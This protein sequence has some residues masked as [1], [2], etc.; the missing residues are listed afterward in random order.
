ML[1]LV[2]E[3]TRWLTRPTGP[4]GLSRVR[5]DRLMQESTREL[6]MENELP[7]ACGSHSHGRQRPRA[8]KTAAWS[9]VRAVSPQLWQKGVLARL[10]VPVALALVLVSRLV[11]IGR[12]VLLPDEAYYWD[13][14]RRLD[15]GY[16]D[17]P[18]LVAL[19][20]RT[21]T[22]IVGTSEFT[23]RVGMAMLGVGTAALAYR[24][25]VLLSGRLAGWLCLLATATCPLFVLLSGFAA[26]D[27]PLLFLWA[28]TVY[29][30]LRA[31]VTGCG[32]YWYAAGI[33]L[34]LALLAKYV[35]VLLIPSILLF[36]S[37]SRRGWLR[38]REP[39]LA[40]ALAL[41][42]FSPNVWWNLRHGW[43]SMSFQLAHGACQAGSSPSNHL[44]AVDVYAVTQVAIVGPLLA[45]ALVVATA[46]AL[47]RGVRQRQDVALLLVCCT[48]PTSILF[49]AVQGLAH[50]AAP[51]YFSA[52]ICASVFL[53]RVLR[54]AAGWQR[55]LLII[56]CVATLL[57]LAFESTSIVR[58][59]VS[60]AP[61][62]G[63]LGQMIA[64]T[65]M[66]PGLGWRDVGRGVGAV[67]T[68]LPSADH[69]STPVLADS[70]GTAAEVAFYAPTR[71]HVYS[72]SN[73]YRMWGSPEPSAT[74]LF[75][76]NAG[77]P[78][79]VAHL[80]RSDARVANALTV[81]SAGRVV[82]R[83]ELMVMSRPAALED[84][85]AAAWRAAATRCEGS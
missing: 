19:V 81:R 47:V 3:L 67:L 65:L 53:A 56:F 62:P 27:G 21:T 8:G 43:V 4:S 22:M 54:R 39:Y 72:G 79:P 59:V 11:W 26:P 71:P 76:G 36:V 32:R 20:I 10:L 5:C 40:C 69:R 41:L 49:L 16:F 13:W 1:L 23:V 83:L 35:A 82:R 58:A 51:A 18:P 15:L 46:V 45:L 9:L 6:Q 24:A 60:S 12:P 7:H 74:V 14:S 33:L 73:Q 42:V 17:H 48:L 61:M 52:I 80:R 85:L 68:R 77:A 84:L 31:V 34:G 29:A 63:P 30:L 66:E 50:W 28:A 2:A 55:A 64:P 75:I 37:T 70:Y 38:R 57:S 44:R 25:G 78:V